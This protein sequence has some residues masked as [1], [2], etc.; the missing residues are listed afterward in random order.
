MEI[1]NEL[2]ITNFNLE[3][4]YA[5]VLE[6]FVE[7]AA[8]VKEQNTVTPEEALNRMLN[9]LS[10]RILATTE[11]RDGRDSRGPEDTNKISGGSPAG[12]YIIGNQNTKDHALTGKLFLIKKEVQDWCLKHRVDHKHMIDVAVSMGVAHETKDKFNVGR[13]TKVSAGQ[14]RCICIDML[15]LEAQGANTPALSVVTNIRMEGSQAANT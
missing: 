13:G 5:F 15:K 10:P 6:L 12:R 11:Y 1:T 2:G 7:L 8:S 14:H 4:L 9:E 3:K